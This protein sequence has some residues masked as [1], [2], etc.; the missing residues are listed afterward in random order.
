MMLLDERTEEHGDLRTVKVHNF[1]WRNM[2][3]SR[4]PVEKQLQR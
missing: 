3:G 1:D 4:P 2:A